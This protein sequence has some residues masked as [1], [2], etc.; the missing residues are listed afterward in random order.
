MIVGGR[1]VTKVLLALLFVTAKLDS[2]L[3][4][5]NGLSVGVLLFPE[6]AIDLRNRKYGRT[7]KKCR[8]GTSRIRFSIW[9]KDQQC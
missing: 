6:T 7:S 8:L 4:L 9:H 5:I 2:P 3:K 1:V